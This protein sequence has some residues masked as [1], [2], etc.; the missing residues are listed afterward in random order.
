[1]TG[2]HAS[3][4]ADCIRSRHGRRAIAARRLALPLVVAQRTFVSHIVHR[5]LHAG[6]ICTVKLACAVTHRLPPAGI[7]SP[8]QGEVA[9]FAVTRPLAAAPMIVARAGVRS[10]VARLAARGRRVECAPAV[11]AG[12][13]SEQSRAAAHEERPPF[14]ARSESSGLPLARPPRH[15]PSAAAAGPAFSRGETA[16]TG[17]TTTA[18]RP[19][20]AQLDPRPDAAAWGQAEI[21]RLTARV[22]G[23]IDRRI[24]AERE[25]LGRC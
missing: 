19:S 12:V 18:A 8:T 24:A 22:I 3:R 14:P 4:F 23:S 1:M 11:T 5:H 21:D 2:T 20:S 25:R 13:H 15:A 7:A 6:S 10:L 9:A 16:F 17:S